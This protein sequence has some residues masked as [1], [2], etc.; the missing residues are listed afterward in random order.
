[1]YKE[2]GIRLNAAFEDVSFEQT[3]EVANYLQE[4]LGIKLGETTQ[5][6]Q[7]TLRSVECL[8]ACVNA[9]VMQVDNKDYH[10][11]LTS[12]SIDAVLEHLASQ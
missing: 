7:F 6:T 9:P 1:M 3:H 11:N 12:K 4:K 10:E 2:N 8:G 5:D